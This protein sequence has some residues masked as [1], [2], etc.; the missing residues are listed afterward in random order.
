MVLAGMRQRSDLVDDVHRFILDPAQACFPSTLKDPQN[1]GCIVFR[2]VGTVDL[3][4][5]LIAAL[6]AFDRKSQ[7]IDSKALDV[8]PAIFGNIQERYEKSELKWSFNNAFM[9]KNVDQ[10]ISLLR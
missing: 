3:S 7:L 5:L 2:D 1:I 6:H 8:A 4:H 9:R 10:P